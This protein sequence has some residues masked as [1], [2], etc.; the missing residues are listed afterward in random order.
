[1]IGLCPLNWLKVEIYKVKMHLKL[2]V[3]CPLITAKLPIESWLF[4]AYNCMVRVYAILWFSGASRQCQGVLYYIL[5]TREE[6]IIW[7]MISTESILFLPHGKVQTLVK[8]NN[9]VQG[10]SVYVGV[11]EKKEKRK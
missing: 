9:S 1:M 5:L 4:P 10:P 8:A 7:N 11:T 2:S 3:C 6:I